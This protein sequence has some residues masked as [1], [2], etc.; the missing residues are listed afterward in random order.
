MGFV[1]FSKI[2]ASP[3]RLSSF[4]SV[5]SNQHSPV[6]TQDPARG[7]GVTPTGQDARPHSRL[8]GLP[9]TDLPGPRDGNHRC[10]QGSFQ[11]ENFCEF[12]HPSRNTF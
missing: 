11:L 3:P 2:T 12:L 9:G 6:I 10:S 8:A 4:S 7:G 1:D 5:F